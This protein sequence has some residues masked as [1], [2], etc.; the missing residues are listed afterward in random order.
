MMWNEPGSIFLASILLMA[1]LGLSFSMLMIRTD[2]DR[3]AYDR[4]NA[5]QA[6]EFIRTYVTMGLS[7]RT[8]CAANLSENGFGRTLTELTSLSQA[9]RTRLILPGRV[10]GSTVIYEPG[11]TLLQGTVKGVRV[12]APSSISTV[13]HAYLVSV[14]LDLSFGNNEIVRTITFPF[15]VQSAPDGSLKNCYATSLV[16]EQ[17]FITAEDIL[18]GQL[19]PNSAFRYERRFCGTAGMVN[20]SHTAYQLGEN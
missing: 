20:S 12:L 3:H 6:M 13:D 14:A 9:G 11:Q 8:A 15:Y 16:D 5:R 2:L 1:L 18:C 7:K 4:A 17:R 10:P 19:L